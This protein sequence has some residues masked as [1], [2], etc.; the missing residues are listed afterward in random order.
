MTPSDLNALIRNRRAKYPATY[1]GEKVDEQIIQTILENANWAPSHKKTEPWRF[2][3][4]KEQAMTRLSEYLA[5]YYKAKTPPEKFS[6][7]KYSK[8]LRKTELCSHVIAICMERDIHESVPEWEEMAAVACAVQ[9]MWLTCTAHRIGCYWST[10]KAAL[11]I[12]EFLNLPDNQRCLGLFY[13]G[14]PKPITLQI[15]GER[16]PIEE[17]VRW[18]TL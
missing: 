16:G 10:P 18:L 9:N 6:E 14:I 8:T 12:R 4:L 1:T 17:K 2:V 5:Q 7:N 13:I 11:D 3:V 15:L